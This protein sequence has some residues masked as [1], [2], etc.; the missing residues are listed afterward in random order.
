MIKKEIVR[1][2]PLKGGLSQR[3]RTPLTNS[4]DF[5]DFDLDWGNIYVFLQFYTDSTK[6]SGGKL[7]K[8]PAAFLCRIMGEAVEPHSRFWQ[9]YIAEYP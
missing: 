3:K 8:F 7:A 9:P 4:P 1:S 2:T 6:E 5:V